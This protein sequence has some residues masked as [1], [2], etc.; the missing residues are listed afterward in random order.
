MSRTLACTLVLL[1]GAR[2]PA[3]AK[4]PP[5]TREHAF[6]VMPPGRR[7]DGLRRHPFYGYVI[8]PHAVVDGGVV[9]CAYQ[10]G[11][12]EPMVAS[13]DIAKKT[14][15]GPV[16]ASTFG[17]GGDD[18]GNPSFYVDRKGYLHVFYGCHGRAMRHTKSVKPRDIT[19]WQEQKPPTPRA[20]YPQSMRLS[21]GTACLFYRAGGHMAPWTLRTSTDDCTTWSKGMRIIE[22]RVKPRD[23]RAAAY[24][25]FRPG[26]DGKTIHC[27]WNFK[28]DNPRRRPKAYPDLHEAVYRYNMYYVRRDPDGVWRT[29]AGEAVSLPVSKAEADAKCTAYD[30]GKE[31]AYPGRIAVDG[32]DRPHIKLSTGV[33]DWRKDRRVVV[34][35]RFKYA[36]LAEGKW[37]VTDNLPDGWSAEVKTVISGRGLEAFGDR[38]RGRWFI[39]YRYLP[40]NSVGIFLYHEATGYAVRQK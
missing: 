9:Y 39:F 23:P 3:A 10:N 2:A 29:R 12:G 1:A 30:S 15:A 18:H 22:M 27:F 8:T 4:L 6:V 5:P 11:R 17:L 28:D 19:K 24:C 34:P 20:T 25:A 33:R 7:N 35:M 14:R 32:K 31:F 38:S 16:R 40:D 37:A 36:A 13:Y 21:D 26:A